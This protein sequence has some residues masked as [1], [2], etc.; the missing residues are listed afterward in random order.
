MVF[1]VSG[2]LWGAKNGSKMGSKPHV[3]LHE[4]YV[5]LHEAY[6]EPHKAYVEPHKA[7]C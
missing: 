3:E 6:V 4:A 7:L 2:V 5:E 1:H